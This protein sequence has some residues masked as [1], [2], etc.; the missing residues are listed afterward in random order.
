MASILARSRHGTHYDRVFKVVMGTL[1]T[2]TAKIGFFVPA[3]NKG[4]FLGYFY[5]RRASNFCHEVKNQMFFVT[6]YEGQK[7]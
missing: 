2:D 7:S 1:P 3:D 4:H 5:S 6:R